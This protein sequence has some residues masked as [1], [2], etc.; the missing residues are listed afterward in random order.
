MSGTRSTRQRAAVVAALGQSAEFRSAQQLHRMLTDRGESV[1]L[2]TV[3]RTLQAMADRG[4]VD[5]LR[6]PDGE[7]RYRQCDDAGHHHHL[8]CRR[9]GRTVEL[10]ALE[11]EGWAAAMATRYGF[12]QVEHTLELFGVCGECG[13]Q[14]RREG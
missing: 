6:G 1:G 11:L 7:V 13:S 3:Y 5:A 4:E 8:V 10:D 12:S 9:C 14:V 2:A